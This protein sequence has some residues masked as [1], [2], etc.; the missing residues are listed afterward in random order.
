MNFTDRI[1]E[2]L[3]NPAELERLFRED[4]EA[5]QVAFESVFAENPDAIVL[6]VWHERLHFQPVQSD[7]SRLILADSIL[8]LMLCLLA[9]TIAKLPA[10]FPQITENWFYPRNIAFVI[11]PALAIYFLTKNKPGK[12]I[13]GASIALFLLPLVFINTLPNLDK[14]DTILLSCLH[15]PFFLWAVL[16]F[17]FTG[18]AF[19]ESDRRMAYL[20]Y[21]A[22]MLIYT[23][24]FIICGSLL[25]GVTA[26][27]FSIISVNLDKF[28]YEY[29]L[30]YALC[31]APIVATHLTHAQ[32]RLIGNLAPTIA[33][34]FSPLVLL[35]LIAYLISILTLQRNPFTDREFLVVFNVMLLGVLAIAIFTLS[36]RSS[37]SKKLVG[38]YITFA[39]IAI[40]LM[41]DAVALA[42]IAFR[43]AS[44]GTTPNR[45]VVLGANLLVF[46]N[47]AGMLV[48]YTRFFLGKGSIAE[49]KNWITAYLPFYGIWAAIVLFAFPFVFAFK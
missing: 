30:I 13:L 36:E 43:L 4:S 29:I 38:D 34:I 8:I 11:F 5:F 48:Q 37:T 12:S 10:Y 44:Y 21:N 39:L 27:L 19:R 17:V 35:T 47:L 46:G 49:I 23:T 1:R 6:K 26:G 41:V 3:E 16:G 25:V 42:A 24:L 33:R 18:R 45:L 22:E 20:K 2:S 14:S 31:A 7:Q 40:A 32:S 15:L 28:Y 9:G